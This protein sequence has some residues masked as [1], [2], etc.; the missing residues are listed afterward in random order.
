[1]PVPSARQLLCQEEC[2]FCQSHLEEGGLPLNHCHPSARLMPLVKAVSF[3]LKGERDT[4]VYVCIYVF[5]H[6]QLN[7]ALEGTRIMFHIC[8]EVSLAPILPS[9]LPANHWLPS[10]KPWA[11]PRVSWHSS[12]GTWKVC[13]FTSWNVHFEKFYLLLRSSSSSLSSG[14]CADDMG[15][16]LTWFDRQLQ[17]C[18]VWH[19]KI[20]VLCTYCVC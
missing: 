5:E 2:L 12:K 11:C 17:H 16:V 6:C 4:C 13:S 1:M 7:K 14:I 3:R 19:H 9:L 15:L 10:A 20:F 18:E 8:L